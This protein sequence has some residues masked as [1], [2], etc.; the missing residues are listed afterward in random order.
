M[1]RGTLQILRHA[2][3]ENFDHRLVLFDSP[4]LGEPIQ[5]DPGAIPVEYIPRRPGVDFRFARRLGAY[6]D[7]HQI[8]LLHTH[9]DSAMFY[10]VR[11]R[12]YV[13]T[14]PKP[15]VIASF[16]TQPGHRTFGARIAARWASKRTAQVVTVS[17][18][19]GQLLISTGWIG[20]YITILNG[21]D[22]TTFTPFGATDEWRR[23]LQVPDGAVLVGH[24]G[25]F[26]PVKRQSDL[27]DAASALSGH[28]PPLIFVLVGQGPDYEAVKT[29]AA[30]CPTVRFVDRIV[31]IAGFYRSLDIFVLCSSHEATPRALLE[32]MSC[33]VPA[34]ATAV[35]GVPYVMGDHANEAGQ[36]I[37]SGRPDLLAHR[38][39]DLARD[40]TRRRALS[41]EGL[42]R[43]RL[44]SVER[45]WAQYRSLYAQTL[46]AALP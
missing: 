27:I 32:A 30:H 7:T 40:S 18:E 3:R 33:G 25:R 14:R 1:Q 16:H 36:L 19:L 37:P 41:E 10:G 28:D 42:R 34:I 6:I 13:T 22:K 24:V 39:S 38:L 45:E 11:A 20:N 5:Y 44:F 29:R 2:R 31:D 9:N 4:P 43:S 12:R 17:E 26:D 35:G 15:A 21:V 46:A 23:R 8:E